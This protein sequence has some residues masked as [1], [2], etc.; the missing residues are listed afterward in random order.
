MFKT[1]KKPSITSYL[2]PKK[3]QVEVYD[4]QPPEL[5]EGINTTPEITEKVTMN[6]IIFYDV[7]PV[8]P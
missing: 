3:P 5:N 6:V 1:V 8:L 7:K 2:Q 4:D